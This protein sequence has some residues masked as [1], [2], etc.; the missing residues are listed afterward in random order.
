MGTRFCRLLILVM[1]IVLGTISSAFAQQ[2]SK[3]F[4]SSKFTASFIGTT[5]MRHPMG[6]SNEA[7]VTQNRS[8]WYKLL[9]L[10]SHYGRVLAKNSPGPLALATPSITPLPVIGADS[11]FSGFAAVNGA[12]QA[13]LEGFDLEPP[14]QGLCTNGNEVM[15]A[16]NLALVVYD[17]RTHNV[18]AGPMGL[19]SFFGTTASLSDPRCY[20]DPPTE[21]W[22]ITLTEVNIPSAILLA[23]SASSDPTDGYYLYSIDTTNDGVLGACPCFGDQPLL[24]ADTNGLYIST[25]SFSLVTSANVQAQIYALSKFDLAGEYPPVGEHIVPLPTPGE[26]FPFSLGPELSPYGEGPQANGGTE[27]LLASDQDTV[28]ANKVV[29]WAL[30]NTSSLGPYPDLGLTSTVVWT[31]PYQEPPPATQKIGPIP[32]GKSLGFSEGQLDPDDDR[33]SMPLYFVNGELWSAINTAVQVESNTL[34]GIAYFVV[35]PYWSGS[36]LKGSVAQQGYI[37]AKGPTGPDN[38]IYPAFGVTGD[39]DG[40][41][42]FTLTGP[43]Y[44]PSA[45]YV[46]ISDGAPASAI[47]LAGKGVDPDDGF[48]EYPPYSNGVGRWGDYSWAVT[49]GSTVWLATEYIGPKKRDYYTNWGTFIGSRPLH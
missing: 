42:V 10:A 18:L 4:Q 21:R 44:F 3:R 5:S 9:Y 35:H 6:I 28:Q 39:G 25:N 38:L 33:M 12:E 45:A 22:F 1:F 7:A 46:P 15:E 40:A 14:D 20:Y 30:T 29:L 41:M 24:G 36:V 2:T 49:N 16:I 27:Y 23:V 47:R 13:A 19:N 11:D 43:D 32:L 48:T 37:V 26:P 8:K 17:T 34:A 31:K